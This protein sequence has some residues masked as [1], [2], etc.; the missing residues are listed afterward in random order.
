MNPVRAGTASVSQCQDRTLARSRGSLSACRLPRGARPRGLN[1]SRECPL[2]AVGHCA[3][4]RGPCAPFCGVWRHSGVADSGP[5]IMMGC[6]EGGS[7]PAA[8][9]RVE[10][11]A[12]SCELPQPP[13]LLSSPPRTFL[14]IPLPTLP[15]TEQGGG[16]GTW[17][18]PAVFALELPGGWRAFLRRDC[19]VTA[20]QSCFSALPFLLQVGEPLSGL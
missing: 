3:R 17:S 18:H 8:R 4:G 20:P 5:L 9:S 7:G 15:V 12:P 10:S 14:G 13:P 16:T 1:T 6:R 11:R 2:G 19:G